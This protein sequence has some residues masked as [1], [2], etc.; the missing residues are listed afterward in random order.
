MR[1]LPRWRRTA[2]SDDDLGLDLV[3]DAPRTTG[4][5]PTAASR[6]A[7]DPDVIGLRL[8]VEHDNAAAQRT[9]ADLGLEVEP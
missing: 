1:A 2:T 8:Y 9:Y 4:S 7:A 5:T 6:A 3:D